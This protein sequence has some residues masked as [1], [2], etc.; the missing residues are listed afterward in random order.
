MSNNQE[1]GRSSLENQEPEVS[2]NEDGPRTDVFQ[3][4]FS[5]LRSGARRSIFRNYFTNR[6]DY[7]GLQQK[8][9]N[10]TF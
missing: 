5:T 10:K 9:L 8:K 1:E 3:K 7:D 4:S 2:E 6:F